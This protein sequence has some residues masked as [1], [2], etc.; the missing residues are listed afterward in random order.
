ML[1]ILIL[2]QLGTLLPRLDDLSITTPE[3]E[4]ETESVSSVRRP[5]RP[6][7]LLF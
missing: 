6:V 2:G 1:G 5:V 3:S 4:D 7:L